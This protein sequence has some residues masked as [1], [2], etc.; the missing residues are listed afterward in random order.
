MTSISAWSPSTSATMSPRMLVVTTTDGRSLSGSATASS[1]P[2]A[3][4]PPT[5]SA[6]TPTRLRTDLT[7]LAYGPVIACAN[8]NE[9]H[10]DSVVAARSLEL[11]RSG[12]VVLDA[13]DLDIGPG[14]TS[15]VGPNGSGKTTLLHAIAGLL[16]PAAG[17]LRVLGSDPQLVRDRI[18]YVLQAQHAPP[19]LPVTVRE[20]VALGRA[21][22]RGAFR[23]LRRIDHELVED[24][25]DVVG[26]GPLA[27]RHL[28]ELSGGQRQRAFVAQGLAQRADVLLLD[29]PT[30]GLDLTST[31]QIRAVL[32]AEHAAGRT[33][34]V[35]THDLGDAA[36]SDHVVLLAGRVVAAGT[37]AT[38]LV[39]HNLQAAYGG[40]LLDLDGSLVL[41][42]DD[43]HHHPGG[44]R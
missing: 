32:A 24:A 3:A 10:A 2:H 1:S 14:V 39:R 29:E 44:E 25:I 36:G 18:A 11:S 27:N 6:P 12:R 21:A 4:R 28:G 37:P 5:T 16:A 9:S 13:G 17:T 7:G 26:L 35:A 33:I 42:D 41:V 23:R 20:I 30:A 8:G 19:H 34:V 40:R 22:E 15:L 43:A 38:V 31:D